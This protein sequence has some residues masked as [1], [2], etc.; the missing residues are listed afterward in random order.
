M[1]SLHLLPQRGAKPE[2][3]H[4]QDYWADKDEFP[5]IDLRDAVFV[6]D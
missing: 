5:A 1:R 6:Y 4:S 3:Q 2:W